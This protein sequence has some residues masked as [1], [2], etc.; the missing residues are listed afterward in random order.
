MPIS[1]YLL[2]NYLHIDTDLEKIKFQNKKR[3][4]I[5]F[6]GIRNL[7]FPRVLT[8]VMSPVI[9]NET[10]HNSNILGRKPGGILALILVQ[11]LVFY[12]HP[13]YV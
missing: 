5:R 1:P 11:V 10:Y 2:C 8:Y 6:R 7:H 4:H 9:I 12:A 13:I 3:W